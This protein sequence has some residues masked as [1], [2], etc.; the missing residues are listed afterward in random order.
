M[1]K[2]IVGRYPVFADIKEPPFSLGLHDTRSGIMLHHWMWITSS[3]TEYRGIS[4]PSQTLHV[5]AAEYARNSAT[6]STGLLVT[7][8]LLSD[9]TN[10]DGTEDAKY[11]MSQYDETARFREILQFFLRENPVVNSF[12]SLLLQFEQ[13][14]YKLGRREKRDEIFEIIG[15]LAHVLEEVRKIPK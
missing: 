1:L 8:V 7:E 2:D 3:Y 14:G 13:H 11:T 5:F 9:S 6:R 15:A 12:I 4:H 10:E